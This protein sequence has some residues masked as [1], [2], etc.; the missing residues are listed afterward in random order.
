[1][2]K[3]PTTMARTSIK[4]QAGRLTMAHLL[5][6]SNS[7]HWLNIC[8][9][10]ESIISAHR[11]RHRS[12]LNDR[13]A[14][15]AMIRIKN[16]TIDQCRVLVNRTFRLN[17]GQVRKK[18]VITIDDCFRSKENVFLFVIQVFMVAVFE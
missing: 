3:K 7:H 16:R 11:H 4:R 2:M 9:H 14:H 8:Q 15:M 6:N 17:H 5:V 10:R 1:M 13:T 18:C 12:I